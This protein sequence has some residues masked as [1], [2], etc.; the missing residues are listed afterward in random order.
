MTEPT[1]LFHNPRCSKS[2]QTLELLTARGIE[3]EIIRYLETPPTE[4]ELAHILDALGYEP[5][6][7][8]RTKEKEYKDLGLDNPDLN[9]DQLIAAMTA[10]PK[11]IERPI[12]LA[13]GKV[14][15]GRPP[16][17]VLSIL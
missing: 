8:M 13:N 9:R 10:N 6:E 2:R 4:Q 11:L 14:A 1:R 5:R 17:N 15:V 16:E 7:L 12:V 3:P